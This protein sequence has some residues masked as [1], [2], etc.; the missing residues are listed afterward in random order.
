[1]SG[2]V[3]YD[4]GMNNGDDVEYYLLKGLRVV[5]VEANAA[6]CGMAR[7]RF[8]ESI[9]S[10]QLVIENV[11]LSDSRDA[12]DVS[13]WI[14]RSNNVL[15]RFP[16]P[17]PCAVH[18][19]FETKVPQRSAAEIVLHYG[20][21]HYIKID[22]ENFD[23]VVLKNLFDNKI[24]PPFL[25]AE[26][27]TIDVWC[28]MVAAGYRSFNVVEGA[29]VPIDYSNALIATPNGQVRHSFPQH[30]AG[31]FGADISSSWLDSGALFRSLAHRGLGWKDVHATTEIEPQIQG[32]A[33]D[34]EAVLSGIGYRNLF[35]ALPALAVRRAS[36]MLRQLVRNLGR[37]T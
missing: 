19:F 11:V 15:S 35:R 36:S 24:R 34:M 20:E 10:G 37:R 14:H 9:R 8:E 6:L 2:P 3:I 30:S 22:I 18:E 17:S 4:F 12:G 16:R 28:L 1:M 29:R 27:H 7:E 32:E 25:S 23:G 33:I 5:G 26:V 31:P 21:P 13:F